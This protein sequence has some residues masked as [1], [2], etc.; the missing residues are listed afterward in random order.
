MNTNPPPKL[1]LSQLKHLTPKPV[2]DIKPKVILKAAPATPVTDSPSQPD[3]V[4]PPQEAL[5]EIPKPKPAP[6]V[7]PIMQP[8]STPVDEHESLPVLQAFQQFLD[9]ERKR[10]RSRMI[11]LTLVLVVLFVLVAGISLTVA[12]TYTRQFTKNF[13]DM[14]DQVTTVQQDAEKVNSET[15]NAL[16][17][18]ENEAS[19]LQRDVESV[20]QSTTE[21]KARTESYDAA[22]TKLRETV[23]S[24]AAQNDSLRTDVARLKIAWPSEPQ[25]LHYQSIQQTARQQPAQQSDSPSTL[26]MPIVPRGKTNAVAWRIPL[27]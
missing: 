3:V 24:L 10:T 2:A 12:L 13:R 20:S 9:I 19:R 27:P 14:K 6:A 25:P 1:L 21:I 5:P 22:L 11:T 4:V 8:A 16:T 17:N 7:K 23:N 18:F 26:V 15:R